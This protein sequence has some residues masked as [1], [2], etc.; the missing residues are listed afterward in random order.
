MKMIKKTFASILAI[1]LVIGMMAGSVLPAS[2]AT[3]AGD[4]NEDGKVNLLD[5][6][7]ALRLMAGYEYKGKANIRAMFVTGDSKANTADAVLMLRNAA[8]WTD[9]V[10]TAPASTIK[11][12]A[13]KEPSSTCASYYYGA[14]VNVFDQNIRHSSDVYY[15]NNDKVNGA[16]TYTYTKEA[17]IERFYTIMENYDPDVVGLQEY[18]SEEWYNAWEGTT[19]HTN[20]TAISTDGGATAYMVNTS[21]DSILREGYSGYIQTRA[22]P[23]K[24][25]TTDW[26]KSVFAEYKA[27]VEAGEDV[28][29]L[30]YA[31][32]SDERL[33]IFWRTSKFE[34]LDKGVFWINNAG[35]NGES[36]PFYPAPYDKSY[37]G[38]DFPL[39]EYGGTDAN[40][41]KKITYDEASYVLNNYNR[42]CIWVKLKDKDTGIIFYYATTHLHKAED[43]HSIPAAQVVMDEMDLVM[44]KYGEAPLVISGDFNLPDTCTAY[45]NL[46]AKYNDVAAE[47]GCAEKTFSA[48]TYKWLGST[49]PALSKRIDF[50]FTE[51]CGGTADTLTCKVV[52][53]TAT[54]SYT[55]N[56]TVYTYE[57]DVPSDH[58]G[59]NCNILINN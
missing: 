52:K 19:G 33:A 14:E 57:N 21:S 30:D 42:L 15:E 4:V 38:E 12:E 9:A 8:G 55:K 45:T 23:K 51:N 50:V 48:Y 20:R 10:L 1:L 54:G 44:E 56:G 22:D 24:T 3:V 41:D 37:S 7:I 17:R 34:L 46:V 29:P 58:Y 16:P 39:F 53:D 35:E 18:R 43:G 13:F 59:L 11:D 26:A 32:Q 28:D 25:N 36:I 47:M 6:A 27:K 40:G 31:Y 49:K 5:V 2:A